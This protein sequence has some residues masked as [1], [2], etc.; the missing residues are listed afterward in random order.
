[1]WY[2]AARAAPPQPVSPPLW[3]STMPPDVVHWPLWAVVLAA[4]PCA[5]TVFAVPARVSWTLCRCVPSWRGAAV[6]VTRTM[7][8]RRPTQLSP[9][10]S[11]NG[12]FSVLS[13]CRALPLS[14]SSRREPMQLTEGSSSLPW[15][16]AYGREC[17]SGV[18]QLAS[19]RPPAAGGRHPGQREK[20]LSFIVTLGSSPAD[21]P[22]PL[23][24][25]PRLDGSVRLEP[26]PSASE[27][28]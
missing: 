14:L 22:P 25:N 19:W 26:S 2:R 10:L 28:A 3:L 13:P 18:R 9:L 23:D 5:L 21:W 7:H 20:R 11:V 8:A 15:S 16:S 6:F 1:M 12:A 24:G 17:L 4:A 27:P